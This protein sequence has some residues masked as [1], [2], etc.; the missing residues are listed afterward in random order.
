MLHS[1]LAFILLPFCVA[2]ILIRIRKEERFMA[3]E[4]SDY[5]PY[6]KSGAWGIRQALAERSRIIRLSLNRVGI[7]LLKS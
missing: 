2:G 7:S 3:A 6:S 5:I 1:M 4:F